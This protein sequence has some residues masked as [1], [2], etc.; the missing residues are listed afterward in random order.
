MATIDD[1]PKINIEFETEMQR[2]AF[3]QFW[4]DFQYEY[5]CIIPINLK[6]DI[7][8]VNLNTHNIKIQTVKKSPLKLIKNDKS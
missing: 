4:D 5:N 6:I 2:D 8:R 7:N 3:L 1:N